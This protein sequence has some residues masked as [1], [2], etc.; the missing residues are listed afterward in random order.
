[1]DES[2]S[3]EEPIGGVSAAVRPDGHRPQWRGWERG[4]APRGTAVLV[5]DSGE[6]AVGKRPES[7]RVQGGS[8]V[9]A[10]PA[11]PPTSA[12]RRTTP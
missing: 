6:A 10:S 3:C 11:L 9:D 12:P 2:P 1:M 4:R 5:A 7:T 8:E